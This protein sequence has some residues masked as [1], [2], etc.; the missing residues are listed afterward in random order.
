MTAHL[1]NAEE[2]YGHYVVILGGQVFDIAG[3]FAEGGRHA[4]Y[5]DI[6]PEPRIHSCWTEADID[7]WRV[8]LQGALKSH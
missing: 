1:P 4:Y 2:W 3:V 5:R 6:K 7:F 8:R